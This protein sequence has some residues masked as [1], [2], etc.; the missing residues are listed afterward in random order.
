MRYRLPE[1][2]YPF[3]SLDASIRVP[4]IPGI[5]K[6]KLMGFKYIIISRSIFHYLLDGVIY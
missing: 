5:R 1:N 3:H 2:P 6:D 4:H